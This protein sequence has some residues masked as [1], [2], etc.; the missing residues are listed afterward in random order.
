MQRLSNLHRS[1]QQ[2]SQASGLLLA[3]T[4]WTSPAV[5]GLRERRCNHFLLA[6]SQGYNTLITDD[7]KSPILVIIVVV[8]ALCQFSSGREY[9]RR[10]HASDACV[11]VELEA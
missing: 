9:A 2:D 10:I 4:I 5:I 8:V 7:C 11:S 3:F 6:P 1:V